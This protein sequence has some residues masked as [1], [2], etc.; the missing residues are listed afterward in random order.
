MIETEICEMC[1]NILSLNVQMSIFKGCEMSQIRDEEPR[2]CYSLG[3]IR[4][5][6]KPLS[7]PSPTPAP[8]V[9]ECDSS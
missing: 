5:P 4:T 6:D 2:K 3:S 8:G 1:F 9:L 7:S